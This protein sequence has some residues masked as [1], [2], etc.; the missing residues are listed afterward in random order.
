MKLKKAKE[1]VEDGVQNN[2][3]QKVLVDHCWYFVQITINTPLK[4]FYPIMMHYFHFSK[5]IYL[6]KYVLFL[7]QFS[8]L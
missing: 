8:Y 5:I 7:L 6:W 2:Y 1:D 3:Q 4:M